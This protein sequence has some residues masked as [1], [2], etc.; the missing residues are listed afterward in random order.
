[1]A[2]LRATQLFVY[3][4]APAARNVPGPLPVPPR[5]R[6]ESPE[7]RAAEVVY[8]VPAGK[9]AILRTFT[10]VMGNVPPDG[11]SPTYWL[12]LSGG[13]LAGTYYLHWFYFVIHYPDFNDFALAETW[14]PMLVLNAG[15]QLTVTNITPQFL[16]VAG[17]G[18]LLDVPA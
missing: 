13:G 12:S 9:R 16:S 8:T 6:P 1:M 7:G 17:F 11:S 14:Q 5:P 10:A 18:H 15:Q 3:K 4:C 2:V